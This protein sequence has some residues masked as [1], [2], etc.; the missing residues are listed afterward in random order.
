MCS[1]KKRCRD[2]VACVVFLQPVLPVHCYPY[3]Y[4]L[5]FLALPSLHLSTFLENV[6]ILVCILFLA[7]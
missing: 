5:C 4:F 7:Q 2:G 1:K 3:T 6:F